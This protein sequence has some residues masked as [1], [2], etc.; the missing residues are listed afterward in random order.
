M[1][2]CGKLM[3][4][5]LLLRSKSISH[6]KRSHKNLTLPAAHWIE[7]YKGPFPLRAWKRAFFV[8]FIDLRLKRAVKIEASAKKKA[9]K[10]RML[11]STLVWKRALKPSR[12]VLF[13]L[14]RDVESYFAFLKTLNPNSEIDKSFFLSTSVP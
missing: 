4:K 12:P 1:A 3:T 13:N 14:F 2:S 6:F 7:L 5:W 9:I 10:Q 11:F 8:S